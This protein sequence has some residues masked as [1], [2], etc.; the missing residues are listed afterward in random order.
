MP[1]AAIGLVV[2][3]AGWRLAG[4]WFGFSVEEIKAENNQQKIE[5]YVAFN[6]AVAT[7]GELPWRHFPKTKSSDPEFAAK[8]YQ[9]EAAPKWLRNRYFRMARRIHNGY[10]VPLRRVGEQLSM[11]PRILFRHDT[12]MRGAAYSILCCLWGLL[13][14][15]YFGGAITRIVALR[16]TRDEHASLGQ[17]TAHA[18][19]KLWSYFGAPLFPLVGILLLAIPVFVLGL[20]CRAD[21]GVALTGLL[22]PLALIAGLFMMFLLLGTIFGWPFMW[23]AVSTEDTDAFGAFSRAFSYVF[24]RPLHFIF[25]VVIAGLFGIL[26]WI[27]VVFFVR[28]GIDLSI[29]ALAWGGST[30]RIDEVMVGIDS[31]SGAFGIVLVQFWI[32]VVRML[33]VAFAI[34]FFWSASTAIYLLLRRDVDATELDEVYLE[35]QPESYGMPPLSVDSAGVPGVSDEEKKELQPPETSS[36]AEP[37]AEKPDEQPDAETDEKPENPA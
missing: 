9:E 10:M 24:H 12:G 28:S 4:A 20:F 31:G 16:L 17:A 35:E 26:C 5:R 3:I 36:P 29:Y 30:E 1:L 6:D 23:A 7:A 2:T 34:S 11:P 32:N 21:I 25:Y 13:V 18:R 14:W 37:A 22:W 8:P 33:A 19:A 27:L 15:A